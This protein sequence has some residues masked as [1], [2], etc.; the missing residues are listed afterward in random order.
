MI[1]ADTTARQRLPHASPSRVVVPL[2]SVYTCGVGW[3]RRTYARPPRWCKT[4]EV[5]IG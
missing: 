5:L 2:A 4:S 3:A 1:H